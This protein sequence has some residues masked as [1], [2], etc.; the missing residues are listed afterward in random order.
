MEV[1]NCLKDTPVNVLE[2]WSI[3][4]EQERKKKKNWENV[5][6]EM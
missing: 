3:M 2:K 6:V 4:K 5:I 1:R